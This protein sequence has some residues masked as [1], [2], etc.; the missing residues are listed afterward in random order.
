LTIVSHPRSISHKVL[1]TLI[2]RLNHVASIRPILR[3]FLGRLRQALARTATHAYTRLTPMERD[4]VAWWIQVLDSAA[5]GWDINLLTIRNPNW[6][7]RTD[8]CLHGLGG[9]CV[10]TG[11]AWQFPIPPPWAGTVPINV[12]EFMA[13]AIGLFLL[14]QGPSFQAGDCL[15]AIGDNQSSLCWISKSNFA[16]SPGHSA[17]LAIARDIAMTTLTQQCTVSSSWIPGASNHVADCLSRCLTDSPSSLS[18]N[19]RTHHPYSLQ[20]PPSFLIRPLPPTLSSKIISWLQLTT[21]ATES[22]SPLGPKPTLLGAAGS[23]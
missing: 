15:L 5:V 1:E 12:L 17:P 13:C 10:E 6:S 20:V 18:H 19:I 16:D 4:D 9:Y 11:Q 14:M 3:H 23:N 2:G 8:A 7:C 22:P 21:L